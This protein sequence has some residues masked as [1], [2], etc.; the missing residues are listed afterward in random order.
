MN[1]RG[2]EVRTNVFIGGIPAAEWEKR[3]A[4]K[5]RLLLKTDVPNEPW[6]TGMDKY[7]L[8]E[9]GAILA[10]GLAVEIGFVK[11]DGTVA[12]VQ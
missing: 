12:W 10:E 11:P 3:Q 5:K 4:M 7:F 8:R 2:F 1:E 9:D 6:R